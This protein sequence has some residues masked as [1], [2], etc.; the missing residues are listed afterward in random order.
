MHTARLLQ[1][2]D[3]HLFSDP[4]GSLRGTRTLES[5]QACLANARRRHL[6]ADLVAVTG[7]IVQDE[8]DAYGTLELLLEDIDAPVLLIPG[9]HDVPAEMQRRF[10]RPPFQVGGTREIGSWAVVML[11]TS[12]EVSGRGEGRLGPE[13]LH[14]LATELGRLHRSHVLVLLHHPPV[15]MEA[16]GLDAL[17]LTDAAGFLEVIDAHPNVRGVAWGHAHQS[18]DLLRG[19]VRMMCTPATCFQF[20]PRHPAF[21]IDDRPPGYRVIDLGD[22]G[23]IATEVVWLEGYPR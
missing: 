3:T 20:Q 16:A 6:P 9:N 15:P 13:A 17:G 19:G 4:Q 12:S 14:L 8:P 21:A 18:L 2:T 23:S 7:D 22:D 5:L 11:D 10:V 1:F